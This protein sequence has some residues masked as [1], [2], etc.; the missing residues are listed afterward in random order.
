MK[1]Y[2]I[3]INQEEKKLLEY[4]MEKHIS[5][6][7]NLIKVRDNKDDIRR[8]HLRENILISLRSAKL[9]KGGK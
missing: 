9:I 2:S 4:L 7:N 5:I 3:T 6:C 8:K 1:T